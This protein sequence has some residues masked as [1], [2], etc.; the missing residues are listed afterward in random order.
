MSGGLTK[1]SPVAGRPPDTERL[2]PEAVRTGEPFTVF[3]GP[4]VGDVFVDSTGQ[5]RSMEQAL[6]RMLRSEGF[7]RI[8]FSTLHDPVYFRDKES[9]ERSRRPARRTSGPDGRTGTGGMRHAGLRG[10]LGGAQLLVPA[11]AAGPEPGS[12]SGVGAARA[13]GIADP[14]GVMTLTG[15]LRGTEHRTAV[16]FPHAD[17]FLLHNQAPRQLAGALAEWAADGVEG[18]QW[19][20]VFN[21]ASLSQ[22]AAFLQGLG[23]SPQLETFVAERR[24][25]PARGGTHRIGLPQGPELERL[26]HSVRLRKGLRVEWRDLDRVVRAM[27]GQPETARVWR[28]RLEQLLAAGAVLDRGSVRPWLGGSV[29]DERSPWE[30]LAAMP[31]TQ[32]LVRRFENLRAE[33]ATSDELRARGRSQDGEPPSRHLV[34]TGNPGTGKTTVARLVGEMY[35]DVGVLDRGHC[36]EAKVSDLVAGYIGQ[37]AQRTDAV[38]DRALGGVLFIDEA[39]GLS[40]QRDGFGDEAIQALLKRMEDDR[41]QL[42]VVVAGYPDKMNQFLDANPGLRSRFPE[43]NIVTFP[44]YDPGTLHTTLLNR[45][46]QGGLTVEADTAAA[47]RQIVESMH[48][49]RD[50]NFGNVREMRT[51]AD[52]VRSRWSVRVGRDVEQPVGVDDIPDAYRE[53]LPRPAP[54]PAE[55]LASFDRYVGLGPVCAE[56]ASLAQRLRMRQERGAASFDPPHLVFTGPPGTG[57]TTVARLVG[58]LFRALGLLRK[59]HVV[60]VTRADLVGQYVGQTAPRVRDA[61]ERALDGVLF[62]DEAYSLVRDTRGAGGFG[63]EAVDT[64]LREM[65]H[66][67]G[68]LVVIAAGYPGEM[69]E[70]LT[71]NA[72]MRSRFT[73]KVPFP[74]F[75]LDDLGEILRRSAVAG[76]YVLGPGTEERARR[77]LAETRRADPHSFGNAREVRRLMEIMEALKAARWGTGDKGPEFLPEDVPDPADGRYAGEPPGC[78]G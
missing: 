53:H 20:L 37:T 38:V 48:R 60:E 75:S 19:I 77:W 41:G 67:R 61:V 63:A 33:L 73:T 32:E 31:G 50:A 5:V 9:W 56:L 76:G 15:Y 45:L 13:S 64:L 6:W 66:R 47:L 43:T 49:G 46:E 21:R 12:T 11:P 1:G 10:P 72:G 14:F 78:S 57:K 27:A 51:L 62:I 23:R 7:E 55:L 68:Q 4:G 65:E 2:A 3:Y 17:E 71:F 44:D 59:G 69:E 26:V 25:E 29:A 30:R 36:V 35:R 42:V 28:E 24:D 58:E 34:F 22:V 74:A 18:N 8:V 52:A 54:D 40:D 39:Y 16:V 70:L